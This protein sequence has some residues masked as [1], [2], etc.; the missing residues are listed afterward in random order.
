MGDWPENTAERDRGRGQLGCIHGLS[1]RVKELG[2]GRAGG[3]VG[4]GRGLEAPQVFREALGCV[5]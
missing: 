4:A 1:S 3:S 2:S 5:L